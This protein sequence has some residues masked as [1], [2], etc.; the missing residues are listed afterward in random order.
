MQNEN[1][2][3]QKLIT[4]IIKLKKEK[5]CFIVAHNYVAMNLQKIADFVGDSLQMGLAAQKSNAEIILV[6]SIKIMGES[7]KILNPDKKVLMVHSD[8]DCPLANMEKPGALDKLI[9][10]HPN[11]EIVAYVN[12]PAELRAKSTIT[13]T[14][15]NCIDVVKSIPLEK[16][17]IFVP[18]CNIGAW[19]EFKMNRKLIMFT[20]Y[21]AVHHDISLKTAKRVKETFP[22]HTLLVHPEC[23]L[24]VC[25][26]ADIVCS[27]SQMIEFT[28]QNDKIIIGTEMGLFE[29]LKYYYPKKNLKYLSTDMVCENMK[30]IELSEA[31]ESLKFEKNEVILSDEIIANNLNSLQRM[32]EL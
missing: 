28:K 27:T 4:E 13:C 2:L 10:K 23:S 18:D 1:D 32:M 31:I 14:S 11:A 3:E 5:N 21:C 20:S 26:F 22:N 30:E 7:V 8:A 15:A 9:Q 6:C 16:E 29:Q 24:E 12:S 19:V 25:R 17:I